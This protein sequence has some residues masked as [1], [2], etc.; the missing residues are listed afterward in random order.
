LVH[1]PAIEGGEVKGYYAVAHLEK[2]GRLFK[3]MT[4]AQCL[5]H[6]KNH[7]KCFDQK[8]GEFYKGTPWADDTDSMCMKTVLIQLMKLLPK[9]IEL[10]KAIASDG[11]IKTQVKTDMF[12]V[13]NEVSYE[14]L[15]VTPKD[16][17]FAKKPSEV[18]EGPEGQVLA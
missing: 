3:F 18:K 17:T 14:D 4:L 8:T 16:D 15:E 5:E 11:S 2:G 12:D 9:S 7:S 1:R 10:Q 6:G 13:K